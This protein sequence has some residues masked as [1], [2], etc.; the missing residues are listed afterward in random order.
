MSALLT[1]MSSYDPNK[2]WHPQTVVIRLQQWEYSKEMM[3]TIGGN[4]LG[5]E[6][7]DAAVNKAID[8]LEKYAG[9]FFV[10]LEDDDGNT[11][12]CADDEDRT[13]YWFK[14][15]ITGIEIVKQSESKPIVNT[16]ESE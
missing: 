15:M 13:E 2:R 8:G 4:C 16:I 5:Y 9:V 6:I 10:V 14:E 11:L 1:Q 12:T 7:F 3:V